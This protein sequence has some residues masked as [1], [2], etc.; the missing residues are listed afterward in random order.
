M[1]PHVSAITVGVKDFDRAKQFYS[2]GLGWPIHIDQSQRRF[3]SFIRPGTGSSALALY[4]WND[5]ADVAGVAPDVPPD[6][7]GFRGFALV[8][9]VRSNERVDAVLAEAER[10]GGKI[11]RPGQAA[12]WGGYLWKVVSGVYEVGGKTHQ[13]LNMFSESVADD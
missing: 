5:L 11:I 8:H 13:T 4:R 7:T 6:G 2:E 12:R 1:N 10:A 3:A 9:I